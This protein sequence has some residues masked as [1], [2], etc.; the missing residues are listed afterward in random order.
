MESIQ[1][2]SNFFLCQDSHG[3]PLEFP[4][5]PDEWALLAY[6]IK[7]HR[8]VC[9]IIFPESEQ[10]S[11]L[12]H[13]SFVE[14]AAMAS[15][16]KNGNTPR[17]L[18]WGRVDGMAFYTTPMFVSEGLVSYMGR[19]G[20]MSGV[21]ALKLV[22]PLAATLSEL[23]AT[24]RLLRGLNL[25]HLQVIA[26]R[27]SLQPDRLQVTQLGLGSKDRGRVLDDGTEDQLARELLGIFYYCLTA[28]TA[29]SG[30]GPVPNGI[31]LLGRCPQLLQCMRIALGFDH[32]QLALDSVLATLR[33]GDRISGVLND[34][35]APGPVMPKL[36]QVSFGDAWKWPFPRQFQDKPQHQRGAGLYSYAALDMDARRD[37]WLHPLPGARILPQ[38]HF[39]GIS[40]AI[41]KMK[42]ANVP[43]LLLPLSNWK[44]ETFDFAVE[45]H[46]TGLTLEEWML[47][48]TT[49]TVEEIARLLR[50][51]HSSMEEAASHGLTLSCL[52]PANIVLH[53]LGARPATTPPLADCN[54]RMRVSKNLQTVV[55]PWYGCHKG[56]AGPA[57]AFA[58]L[59]HDL[60][61]TVGGTLSGAIRVPLTN[62][63]KGV[64]STGKGPN[65][66]EILSLFE[67]H[68]P[69][70]P[71]RTPVVAVPVLPA[72]LPPVVAVSALPLE[73]P[74]AI[75]PEV[76]PEPESP[77][78]QPAP[79][80]SLEIP[81]MPALPEVEIQQV[82]EPELQ[83]EAEPIVAVEAAETETE[84]LAELELAEP[85]PVAVFEA[86][87]ET[88]VVEE[89][90]LGKE[91]EP[92]EQP[93]E[94]HA[95][96]A[97][98]S[99]EEPLD[100]AKIVA[101]MILR[102]KERADATTVI[103][104]PQLAPDKTIRR[105]FREAPAE[106]PAIQQV[107]APEPV[108]STLPVL[109]PIPEAAAEVASVATAATVEAEPPE[110]FP[111]HVIK[112]ESL[113]RP[114]LP[115]GAPVS[116]PQASLEPLQSQA[117]AQVVAQRHIPIDS[118]QTMESS[119]APRLRVDLSRLTTADSLF[120][121]STRSRNITIRNH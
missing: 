6:D 88:P 9:L 4:T 44:G 66:E 36:M 121:S 119:E 98:S 74:V 19:L 73:A 42:S 3:E 105:I 117:E 71:K 15:E 26:G 69:N 57:E 111:A 97:P 52:H 59:A 110:F 112:P 93:V 43:H 18:R 30:H 90:I 60:S 120:S 99:F 96:P 2:T 84:I 16:M 10:W 76:T 35:Q 109:A 118:R 68:L 12:Q 28:Q 113:S 91:I 83:L 31:Q 25:R 95:E 115:V 72:V 106:T 23:Q 102:E 78:E 65:P 1:L 79:V 114:T 14:R 58:M 77:Q 87:A 37:V 50:E 85:T 11:E 94:A 80:L 100:L 108:A 103:S 89:T 81:P 51:I 92:A 5:L 61:L 64:L 21:T 40:P 104:S 7:Q 22:L 75:I 41:R 34:S 67:L 46:L 53:C 24:P 70:L 13:Q 82:I 39:E 45:A 63:A 27:G 54:V 33:E 8:L 107:T 101:G 38:E 62:W 29:S 48:G 32:G 49:A 86:E 20:P 116:E 17:I 56:N 55:E 47:T